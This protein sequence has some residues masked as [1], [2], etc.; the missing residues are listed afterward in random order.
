[1]GGASWVGWT[2]RSHDMFKDRWQFI[3]IIGSA[4]GE[5]GLPGILT[6]SVVG[7][8]ISHSIAAVVSFHGDRFSELLDAANMFIVSDLSTGAIL[9]HFTALKF[10]SEW[11]RGTA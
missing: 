1:M 9:P 7:S 2:K 6:A 10:L 4:I 5:V 11:C 3:P 8:C